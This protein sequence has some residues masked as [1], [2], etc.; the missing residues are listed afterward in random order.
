MIKQPRYI[1]F[2]HISSCYII[3]G[4]LFKLKPDSTKE[5][6]LILLEKYQNEELLTDKDI[7]YLIAKEN[8]IVQNGDLITLYNINQDHLFALIEH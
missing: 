3:D 8:V 4:Y 6:D 2:V 7:T 1:S 5:Q